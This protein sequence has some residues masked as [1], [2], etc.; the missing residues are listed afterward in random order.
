LYK[1]ERTPFG[2]GS[3]SISRSRDLMGAEKRNV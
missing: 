1:V 3:G 2:N